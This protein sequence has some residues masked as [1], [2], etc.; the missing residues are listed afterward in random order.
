MKI[1]VIC[2]R[3][4]E[5][6]CECALEQIEP[7]QCKGHAAGPT[8]CNYFE[9]KKRFIYHTFDQFKIKQSIYYKIGYFI[10]KSSRHYKIMKL[11]KG[12]F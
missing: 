10:G 11:W 4:H 2:D 3:S 12:I 8:S 7:I 1:D 5:Q 6:C 9:S